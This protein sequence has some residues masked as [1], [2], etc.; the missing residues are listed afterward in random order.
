[1]DST[2]SAASSEA[3]ITPDRVDAIRDHSP[4]TRAIF[5]VSDEQGAQ[6]LA[7]LL[8]TL[9][10]A[11]S[12]VHPNVRLPL[13]G[14]LN[15][16]G[17]L[18]GA[19]QS[20]KGLAKSISERFFPVMDGN[21][22][23]TIQD[24]HIS[25]GEGMER[26]YSA[27]ESKDDDGKPV[28][29]SEA[30][31]FWFTDEI[32]NLDAQV[33]SDSR[34]VGNLCTAFTAG[35][36]GAMN[37]LEQRHVA[38]DSYRMAALIAGQPDCM[39]AML[40]TADQGLPQ[41]FIAVPANGNQSI[42]QIK[43]RIERGVI[44]SEEFGIQL[45]DD[46]H[47]GKHCTMTM[48]VSVLNEY[49]FQ[50]ELAVNGHDTEFGGHGNYSRGKLAGALAILDSRSEITEVDWAVAGHL[51]HISVETLAK[52]ADA[53]ELAGVS[54]VAK[55]IERNQDAV[56]VVDQKRRDRVAARLAKAGE[57]GLPVTG[58]GSLKQAYDSKARKAY[59]PIIDAMVTDG[60]IVIAR[61][62]SNRETYWLPDL[63]P[64]KKA[65][66]TPLR[67][68]PAPEHPDDEFA[69]EDAAEQV[70]AAFANRNTMTMRRIVEA[71]GMDDLLAEQAVQRLKSRQFLS[72]LVPGQFDRTTSYAI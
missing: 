54:Q 61:N 33:K 39:E 14:S 46:F 10:R 24:R 67:T 41:R 19:P 64:G 22:P 42:E 31:G 47:G 30:M 1:M 38:A 28:T 20:G 23:I 68:P 51:M 2:S 29:S 58:Q 17:L 52:A 15:M 40:N 25:T 13:N 55:A 43:A 57:A 50:R 59:G 12:Q 49:R 3:A 18:L 37:A 34:L 53:A 66:V 11:T 60:E 6:P 69:V 27:V 9:L 65:T 62:S 45:P 72:E 70:R 8:A 26:F 32:A 63:A 71:T 5:R 36:M 48:P 44:E 21:F 56:A 4:A 7:V 35:S 16:I